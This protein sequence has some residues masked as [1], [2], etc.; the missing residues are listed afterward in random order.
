[1]VDIRQE[2]TVWVECERES[3]RFGVIGAARYFDSLSCCQCVR[4]TGVIEYYRLSQGLS[5]RRNA[6]ES[7]E[8]CRAYN[9]LV[10]ERG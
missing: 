7:C 10:H 8:V 9:S 3:D 2:L 6:Q 4:T 5:S 1:M